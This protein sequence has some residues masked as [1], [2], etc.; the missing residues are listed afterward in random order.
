MVAGVKFEHGHRMIAGTVS[1]LT[2]FS[3]LSRQ[4][5]QGASFTSIDA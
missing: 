3:I 4:A 5:L 1:I 2:M